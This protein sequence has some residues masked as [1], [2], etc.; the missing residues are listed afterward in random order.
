MTALVW[1][2]T[3][4]IAGSKSAIS[5]VMMEITINNSMSVNH[6]PLERPLLVRPANNPLCL[7]EILLS[8]RSNLL[9]PQI[10]IIP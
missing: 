8:N 1:F 6:A 4:R 5:K 3:R 2:L 9:A 10:I 7:P